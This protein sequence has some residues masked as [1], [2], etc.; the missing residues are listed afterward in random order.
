MRHKDYLALFAETGWEIVEE[1]RHPVS[2]DDLSAIAHVPLDRRFQG[3]SLEELAVRDA[4]LVLRK[5]AAHGNG[6][7]PD[8]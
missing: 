3:Y 5:R 2:A 4:R 8:A 7:R 6:R 1:Q